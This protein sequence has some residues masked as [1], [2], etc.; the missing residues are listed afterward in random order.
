MSSL[1]LLASVSA[2]LFWIAHAVHEAEIT[3][4]DVVNEEDVSVID[5]GSPEYVVVTVTSTATRIPLAAETG[6]DD[7]AWLKG[8][9]LRSRIGY[10]Y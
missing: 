7:G 3:T 1:A 4:L 10:G 5:D 2:Q 8:T 6:I 9:D